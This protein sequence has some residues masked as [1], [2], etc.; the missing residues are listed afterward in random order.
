MGFFMFLIDP[1][2]SLRTL[3]GMVFKHPGGPGSPSK[4]TD[5]QAEVSKVNIGTS[6]TLGELV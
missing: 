4:L 5:A 6:K 3:P 1:W 2:C